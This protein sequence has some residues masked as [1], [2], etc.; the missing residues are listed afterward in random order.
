MVEQC[1]D[2]GSVALVDDLGPA[3]RAQC[4]AGD[5][6]RE[7]CAAVADCCCTPVVGQRRTAV[8]S[9]FVHRSSG[10]S[11]LWVVLTVGFALE[12]VGAC[13]SL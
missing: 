13:A 3:A 9:A 8:C 1:S 10:L 4:L 6:T 2:S 7:L 11:C 12:E 5:E